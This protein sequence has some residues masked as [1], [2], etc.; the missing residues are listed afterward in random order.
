M[1]RQATLESSLD[2]LYRS[3]RN[4]ICFNRLVSWY[5]EAALAEFPVSYM[6]EA[7][8]V[9]PLCLL[10]FV[11]TQVVAIMSRGIKYLSPALI[12]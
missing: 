2:E 3:G 12:K 6:V 9:M 4:F 5:V 8:Q 7:V 10:G 1:S 11:Y